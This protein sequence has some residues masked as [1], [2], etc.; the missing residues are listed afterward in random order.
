VSDIFVGI[1]FCLQNAEENKQV[2]EEIVRLEQVNGLH[3]RLNPQI[4]FLKGTANLL[5]AYKTS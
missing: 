2:R 1:P 3:N 5:P 4:I